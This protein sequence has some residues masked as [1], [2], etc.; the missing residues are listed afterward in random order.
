MRPSHECCL[1]YYM[2]YTCASPRQRPPPRL[3]TKCVACLHTKLHKCLDA[4]SQR[5]ETS[6]PVIFRESCD[7][8][9]SVHGDLHHGFIK[10][11][12][13]WLSRSCKAVQNFGSAGLLYGKLLLMDHLFKRWNHQH[14][15]PSR[16]IKLLQLSKYMFLEVSSI[17]LCVFSGVVSIM[18]NHLTVRTNQFVLVSTLQLERSLQ[19]GYHLGCMA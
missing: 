4:R 7:A 15:P 3:Q 5:T 2:R 14:E 18:L 17:V 9:F 16:R 12:Q 8:C 19:V 1:K 10:T 11:A 13:L 6:P